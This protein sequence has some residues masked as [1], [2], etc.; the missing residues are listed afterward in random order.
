MTFFTRYAGLG[1]SL[2]IHVDEFNIWK[3]NDHQRLHASDI[4]ISFLLKGVKQ[5]EPTSF[6]IKTAADDTF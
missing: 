2:I 1:Y 5:L 4:Y 3:H 6:P